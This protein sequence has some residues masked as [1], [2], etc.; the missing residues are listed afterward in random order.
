MSELSGSLGDLGTLVPLMLAVAQD[1]G[2][3][4][5]SALFWAGVFNVATAWY[6]DVPMCVQPMKTIAAVAIAEGLTPGE[7]AGAG[8]GVAAVVLALGLFNG[9]GIELVNRAIP[10]PLISGL[11]LGL[12]ASMIRKGLDMVTGTD[13]WFGQIDCI[14]LGI[15]CAVFTLAALRG[16]RPSGARAEGTQTCCADSGS[17]RGAASGGDASQSREGGGELPAALILFVLG[18]GLAVLRI[19]GPEW[20]DDTL[21]DND[22]SIK[23]DPGLPVRW[24]FDYTT[25]SDVGRGMLKAGLAQIPLT[26]LNSVVSVCAMARELFPPDPE[27][28]RTPAD[29]VTR[30][31]VAASVGFMNLVGCCFGALPMCHGAGGLAGQHRFGARGGA[32]VLMLGVL[33]IAL[34]CLMGGGAEALL[35]GFPSSILGVMMAFAGME[36][37][38]A[39][40][41]ATA[42][43]VGG[44]A[45]AGDRAARTLAKRR[46]RAHLTVM[47][48]T[49]G[50]TAAKKTGVGCLVGLAVAAFH[51]SDGGWPGPRDLGAWLFRRRA[52]GR[53]SAKARAPL[54]EAGA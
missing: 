26:T 19:E 37:A 11:Q 42:R 23:F 20:A 3:D 36:L 9:W 44:A 34:A 51:A 45:P 6:W 28:R 10:H 54:V 40:V 18:C 46:T 27:T 49:A 29:G 13:S 35:R 16:R 2:V 25:P 52:A 21:E 32:S 12:G 24:F 39:G 47:I 5:S 48:A 41:R 30:A 4:L 43:R 22:A 15:V 38:V 31:S 17:D 53:A 1:G 33:K 50:A 8:L 7:I 14:A